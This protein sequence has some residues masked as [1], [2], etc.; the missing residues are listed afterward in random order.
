MKTTKTELNPLFLVNSAILE[1]KKSLD[2]LIN[3]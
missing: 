3:V 1:Y 2:P